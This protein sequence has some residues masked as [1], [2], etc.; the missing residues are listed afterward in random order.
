[1]FYPFLFYPESNMEG[2]GDVLGDLKKTGGNK[3]PPV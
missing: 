2:V 3:S 1:M